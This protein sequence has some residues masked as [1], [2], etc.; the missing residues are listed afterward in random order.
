[1]TNPESDGLFDNDWEERG[2]LA[3][4]EA[5][6]NR[7]LEEQE[8]LVGTYLE[9]Y[10]AQRGNPERVDAVARLMGWDPSDESAGSETPL[11]DAEELETADAPWEPYTVHRNP[12]Y[13][14]TKALA[15]L[16]L[17]HW[18]RLLESGTTLPIAQGLGI[19]RALLR[20][21]E[22]SLHGIHALDLGDYA[23]ALCF[24]KR[25]LASLNE[26]M[27]RLQAVDGRRHPF[28]ARYR[29]AQQPVCFDLREIWLRVMAECRAESGPA[30]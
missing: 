30:D 23:L 12:V 9:H 8:Q 7:Y 28:V 6:W 20:A 19:Q 15:G 5:D 11:P 4:T 17:A 14:S 2:E 21:D 3:W 29:N 27:G 13:V 1:M 22:S 24:F 10:H 26:A 25:A 16:L 18:N